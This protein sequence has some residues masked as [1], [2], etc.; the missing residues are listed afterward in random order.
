M[1]TWVIL[2]PHAGSAQERQDLPTVLQQLGMVD[3]Q[4]TKE[5]KSTWGPLSYLRS[6]LAALPDLTNYQTTITFDDQQPEHVAVY[7]IVLANARY[8]AGGIMIAPEAKLDDG[9]LDILLV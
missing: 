5:V 9:L 8:V 6:A 2:N 1:K 4:L 3:E 7:N